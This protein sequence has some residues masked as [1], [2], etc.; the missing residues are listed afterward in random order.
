MLAHIDY[1]LR[2]MKHGDY[3][4]SFDNYMDRVQQVLRS[5]IDHGYALEL[6]A[7]GIAGWQ[8]KVGPPQDILYEY[9]RWAASASR[10]ARIRTRWI[11]WRAA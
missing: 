2:V 7:A 6:N 11:P 9:K 10:S 3:I 4:P 1:P 8:K 5:C